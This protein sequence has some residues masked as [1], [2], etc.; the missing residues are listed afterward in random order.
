MKFGIKIPFTYFFFFLIAGGIT[1]STLADTHSPKGTIKGKVVD[2]ETKSPLIGASVMLVGT[3]RGSV[4][5]TDGNFTIDNVPVG[6][7]ALKFSSIGYKPLS[8]TDVIIKSDRITFIEAELVITTISSKDIIVTAGYFSQVEDKPGGTINFSTEEIRRSP[9][10]AGDVSRIIGGLPS[11]AKVN[12]QLNSLIVRGGSP[13]ENGFYI[14]NI[15]I[16]NINHYPIPG[17]SGGPIGLLNVDFIQ[18]VTFSAGGFSALHGDRLSSIMDVSFREGNRDE[19]DGEIGIHFAG[20]EIAAEGPTPGKRGSW[21]FS[22]RRSFLDLLVKAIGTGVAPKYSDYQGKITYD[23]SPTN[24]I[25]LLGIYG[26][27]H[28]SFDKEQSIED[29]NIIYGDYDGYEYSFGT[30]WRYLWS[31]NGYS[32]TSISFLGTRSTSD[33]Y[34]TKTDIVLF[35]SDVLEQIAQ[36][37]NVNH[38]RLNELHQLQFGTDAKY[39]LNKYD[40]WMAEYTGVLGDRTD[41]LRVNRDI[42]SPKYGI[43]ANYTWRPFNKLTTN[44]GIRF[45]HFSHNNNSHI[46]PRLSLSYKL[47]ERTSLNAAYGIYYQNIPLIFLSQKEENKELRDPIA[48]HYIWGVSHLL[49]ENTR[50]ILEAYYKE[51]DNFPLDPQ[52][53]QMFIADEVFYGGFMHNH[54]ELISA[55]KVR[56]YGVEMSVQ[57][58]LVENFY[59]L[60]CG[61]YYRTRYLGLDGT[62]RNRVFDNRYI[63]SI[64][65]GYKPNYK[66]EFSVRWIFAGGPPYTPLDI[67]LSKVFDRTVMDRNRVNEAR[68]PDYHSLNIRFDRRYHFKSTNLIFYVSVWNAYNRK[69]IANYYW[70]AIE[71][72]EDVI[73]QWSMLPVFGVEYEF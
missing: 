52:Q 12:D 49:T 20:F 50:L 72:K 59:G 46:S 21:M 70:N 38:L 15:E 60:I 62:W 56:A 47:T 65:G 71:E 33:I 42:N 48:Y 37:R 31:E 63:F 54:E 73:Y 5:D 43:F 10:S 1:I 22:A 53:P 23:I 30:N 14:D 25:T 40:Y 3:R 64:E 8:K 69:N 2:S 35:T 27:D 19:L 7:Y 16:P 41:S 28:I 18:D 68:Y 13:A 6:N 36:I 9:G 57:K 4:T 55:G 29:G 11:I 66:W 45:D 44:W 67:E 61:S 24:K 26:I 39:Y 32:N 58:K 17:S 51:Y 34:E